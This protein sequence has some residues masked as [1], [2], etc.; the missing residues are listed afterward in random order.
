VG[1]EMDFARQARSTLGCTFLLEG[2]CELHGTGFLPLECRFCHH[3]RP[4]QGPLCH[5]NIERDWN[6]PAGR[7]LVVQ[8]SKVTGFWNRL[9][10]GRST[11]SKTSE[12]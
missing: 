2:R 6:T 4:G 11:A 12:R 5:A 10:L 7:A 8:W 1:G 9:N 3:D